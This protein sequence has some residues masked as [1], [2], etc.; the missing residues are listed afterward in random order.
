MS[1]MSERAL[2]EANEKWARPAIPERKER[3]FRAYLDLWDTVMWFRHKVGA[4]LG[5]YRL[6]MERFRMLEMSLSEG[7]MTM[8]AMVESLVFHEASAVQHR[9]RARQA[10]VV[11]N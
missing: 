3:A 2:E 5:D 6:N 7:P 10:R 8:S 1:E 11:T 4:Q 9:R